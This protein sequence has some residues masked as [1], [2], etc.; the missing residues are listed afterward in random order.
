MLRYLSAGES[1]GKCLVAI[2]EGLPAGIKIDSNVINK[3]LKRRQGGYGRGAR[4]RIENDKVEILTG[5]RKNVTLGSPLAL[6]IDN[7]D[8]TLH[9]NLPAILTPRPAH[10]DL[11]GYLKYG[12]R[13]IRDVLERASARETAM[14]VAVGAVT[15][16]FLKE[17]TI[18]VSSKV[19][20]VAGETQEKMR[21]AKI[22]EA[23]K[24]KDTAGG[25][26][27][28]R[29]KN[30]PAGL[31]SYAHYDRRMDAR[32]ALNLMS[33]P[34]IKAVEFGLGFGF[35][36][37]FGSLVHDSIYYSGK[38]GFKRKTN[39]AGGIEG[40]ITNGEPI[41]ARCCMKPIATLMNPLDSVKVTTKAAEKANVQRTDT[42]VV[43]A[44]GVVGE[45]M[46]AFELAAAMLEKFAGDNIKETK[47]N[48][49]GYIENL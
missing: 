41:V 6:K 2:L 39:N 14:R 26:F 11:A 34:G 13:D 19:V 31:G 29:A 28:V 10:A 15:K 3:E 47:R 48:F 17:F 16:I 4:M 20:M 25:I 30:V 8:H 33:I 44:A 36:E 24:A 45:A 43:E 1:H 35:A 23:R 27:E 22:N 42:C 40:G 38:R 37:K 21:R 49:K 18:G 7:K 12:F 32:L 9:R 46:V 5:V